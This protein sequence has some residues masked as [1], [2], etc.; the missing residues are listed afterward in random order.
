MRRLPALP[1]RSLRLL[2][3]LLVLAGLTGALRPAAA[4]TTTP[5]PLAEVQRLAR[6]LDS[7]LESLLA[8][9][10]AVP[11]RVEALGRDE[12]GLRSAAIDFGVVGNGLQSCFASVLDGACAGEPV[13]ALRVLAAGQEP[14]LRDGLQAKLSAT[15]ELRQELSRVLVRSR[16][17]LQQAGRARQDAERLTQEAY[18]RA[19]D[20]D[21]SPLERAAVKRQAVAQWRTTVTE[22][23]R[24]AALALRIEREARP[25]EAGVS[26]VRARLLEELGLFGTTTRR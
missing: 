14:R 3:G 11:P 21:E 12:A 15:D 4:Q 25:L 1:S 5:D 26:A 22:R 20:L 7:E 9:W 2:G 23:D 6:E 8:S 16:L 17:L 10:R 24:V 13:D 19:R 18:Q